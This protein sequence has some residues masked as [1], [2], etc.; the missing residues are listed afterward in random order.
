VEKVVYEH[1]G[2]DAG[3]IAK[4]REVTAEQGAEAGAAFVTDELVDTFAVAGDTRLAV[5]RFR[6]YAEAG[7]RGLIIQHVPGP[8]RVEG[9]RLIAQQVVPHVA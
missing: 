4:V 7:L 9:L 2:A 5:Q 1:S 3:D 8:E 6:E